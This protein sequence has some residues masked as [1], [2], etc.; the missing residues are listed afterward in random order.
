MFLC[1]YLLLRYHIVASYV[2]IVVL[3]DFESKNQS[4]KAPNWT[5]SEI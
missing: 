1:F 3:R 5:D 2:L 4:E